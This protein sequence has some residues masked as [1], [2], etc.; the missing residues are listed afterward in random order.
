MTNRKQIIISISCFGRNTRSQI[1]LL[2]TGAYC[3]VYK[4]NFSYNQIKHQIQRFMIFFLGKAQ[5]NQKRRLAQAAM[6]AKPP[7]GAGE[8]SFL[9][10]R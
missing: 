7:N 2:T 5:F 1:E 10:S 4:Y 6:K 8:E 3:T 9:S